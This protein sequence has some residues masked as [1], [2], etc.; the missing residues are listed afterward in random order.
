MSH[1]VSRDPT[2]TYNE[3]VLSPDTLHEIVIPQDSQIQRQGSGPEPIRRSNS[4]IKKTHWLIRLLSCFESKP[5]SSP[6]PK[7]THWPIKVVSFSAPE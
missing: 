7:K 3:D 4:L 1:V 6:K 5:I 2:D